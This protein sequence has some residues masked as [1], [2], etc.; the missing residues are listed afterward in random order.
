MT[1]CVGKAWE[2]LCGPDDEHLRLRCWQKT[3]CLMTADGSEDQ[4]ITREGL[5]GYKIPPPLLYLPTTDAIPA[6]NVPDVNEVEQNEDVEPLD[7]ELEKPGNEGRQWED[8]EDDRYYDA[9]YCGQKIKVLYQ[10][11]WF[12]GTIDYFNGDIQKFR[13]SYPGGSG[14]YIGA[15]MGP[16]YHFGE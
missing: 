10:N 4:F 14:D 11:G 13:V 7:E 12:V 5:P 16:K 3:G 9:Q 6:P 8:N 1:Q 15:Q 2:K